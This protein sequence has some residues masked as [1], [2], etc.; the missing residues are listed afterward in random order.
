MARVLLVD[1]DDAVRLTLG[2]LLEDA[3]WVVF[4]STCLRDARVILAH[5]GEL[6]VVVLDRS[7]PDGDGPSLLPEIRASHPHAGVIVLSGTA[8][9]SIEGLDG[10]IAKGG[11]P[12]HVLKILEDLAR[13]NGRSR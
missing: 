7:L 2:A 8:G 12:A 6:D 10:V 11:D 4:E 5:A 13:K 9:E 3:G 1:D